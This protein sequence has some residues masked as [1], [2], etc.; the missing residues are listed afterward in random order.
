M[1]YTTEYAKETCSTYKYYEKCTDNPN[2]KRI[3]ISTGGDYV[4]YYWLRSPVYRST[5]SAWSCD[6]D[7]RLSYHW[8]VSYTYAIAGAFAI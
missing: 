7:G 8:D 2:T 4:D 3:K 1:G 6:K 5:M